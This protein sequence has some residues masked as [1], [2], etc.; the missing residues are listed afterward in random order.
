MPFQL[1]D[2][3]SIAASMINHA[4]AIQNKL[5]DFNIGSVARTMLEAPAV[6]IE[7]LYQ[8]MWNGL[9]ES[10]PVAIY[11]SF[12]FDK[13][14]AVPATGTI[15]VTITPSDAPSLVP[16]NTT[17]SPG[18]GFAVDFI[19]KTDITIPANASYVDVRVEAATPGAGGNVTA[20]TPFTLQPPISTMVS[21]VALASFTN[22]AD[23]ETDAQR[24][25]RFIAYVS[26]LTRGTGNALRYGISTAAIRDSAGFIVERVRFQS[27]IEPW[28]DDPG[29]PISLVN[30]YIHNGV[31]GAS[32]A[33][34]DEVT[35]ILYGYTA[36]DGTI[37]PGWKA[38]GVK[39]VVY[40]ATSR[41]IDVTGAV[42]V[43]YGYVAADVI[44]AIEAA[45]SDYITD[46][47]IGADV[48][49]A[50]IVAAAMNVDG[51]VNFQ[52][53]LPAADVAMS[54]TEKAMAGTFTLTAV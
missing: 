7:E 24:K 28:L 9:K 11:N 18:G 29:Q 46:L 32:T 3:P 10:I 31:D 23:Q 14:P 4:R 26:T 16:S 12:D 44:A 22:G 48:L 19:S 47:E 36:E 43:A 35:R 52:M 30:C 6:E 25:T 33:L 39:V 37:V 49:A 51:V 5:T 41:L 42:T 8:Q 27:V 34:I 15:R 54:A 40:A 38:A 13:I 50:E 21:A 53:T 2:F 20:G 17:F 1:K 45:V